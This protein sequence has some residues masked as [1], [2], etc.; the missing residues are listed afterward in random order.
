[1]GTMVHFYRV[2]DPEFVTF[3]WLEEEFSPSQEEGAKEAFYRGWAEFENDRPVIVS[4]TYAAKGI[5]L[6][7]LPGKLNALNPMSEPFKRKGERSVR[8]LPRLRYR[9]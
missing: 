1:M 9:C 5:T 4:I 2:S 7:E 6:D 8:Q 3:F